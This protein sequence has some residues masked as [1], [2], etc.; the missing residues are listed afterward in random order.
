MCGVDEPCVDG[1]ATWFDFSSVNVRRNG[2]LMQWILTDV[3]AMAVFTIYTLELYVLYLDEMDS[4]WLAAAVNV[5]HNFARLT[6]NA[7]FTC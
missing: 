1:D 7:A 3:L 5:E 6:Y 4:A 2:D